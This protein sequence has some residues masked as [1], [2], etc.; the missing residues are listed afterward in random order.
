[1]LHVCS[2]PYH[3]MA[4]KSYFGANGNRNK[5]IKR[6]QKFELKVQR[7]S[8]AGKYNPFWSFIN[9]IGAFFSILVESL[10]TLNFLSSVSHSLIE[11]DKTFKISLHFMII[12]SECAQMHGVHHIYM[13]DC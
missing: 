11:A 1:M 5:K 9:A 3:K 7:K 10:V 12:G 2:P 8:S 4:L 6:L 13:G